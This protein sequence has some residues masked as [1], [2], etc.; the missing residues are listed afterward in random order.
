MSANWPDRPNPLT[1]DAY[2][3]LAEEVRR[4]IEVVDG[5][6]VPREERGRPHQKTAF[7]LASAFEADVRKYRAG[8]SG[9]A[10]PCYEVN[11][12]VSVLLWEVPLT[13]RKPDV[14]VHHCRD[15]FEMLDAGDVVIAVEVMSRWS[16]SRDR[17]HK[18]GEYA[19]A[20]IPHYLIVQFDEVGATIVEHYALLD[21]DLAYSKIGVSHRDRDLWA[22]HMTVPFQIQVGWQDLEVGPPV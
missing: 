20:R 8:H 3:A 15:Q 5:N 1:L 22:L 7:R 4:E 9:G 19:K 14:V 17:I 6:V 16:E 2:L 11:T 21:A 12:E 13:V 18:M 10:P